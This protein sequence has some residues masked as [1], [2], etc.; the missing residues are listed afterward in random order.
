MSRQHGYRIDKVRVR[1]HLAPRK[2]PYWASLGP[3]RAI[4][5]RRSA[6][7]EGTWYSRWRPRRPILVPS[8]G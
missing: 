5:Y 1:N 3:G 7:R 6:V 8:I 4:G 2:E